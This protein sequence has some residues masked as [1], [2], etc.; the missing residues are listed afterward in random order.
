LKNGEYLM[1]HK[2]INQITN[3]IINQ[4]KIH[5]KSFNNSK[6]IYFDSLTKDYS[7]YVYIILELSEW[8]FRGILCLSLKNAWYILSNKNNELA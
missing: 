1:F 7:L 2:I 8:Y 5:F 6:R 3:Q 4:V